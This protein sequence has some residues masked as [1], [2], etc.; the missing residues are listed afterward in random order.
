MAV[1]SVDCVVGGER[2]LLKGLQRIARSQI[3]ADAKSKSGELDTR[4]AEGL[5]LANCVRDPDTSE[6]V[7]PNWQEWDEIP[8]AVTGPLISQL[9]KLN[10]MDNEDL[11]KQEKNSEA[12]DS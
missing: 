3:F 8:A 2:F 12:T 5:L 11:G 10:G 6:P 1:P 4:K 9:M 7:I